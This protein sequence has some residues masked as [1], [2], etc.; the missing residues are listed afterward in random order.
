M[1]IRFWRP[2]RSHEAA[3]QSRAIRRHP[4]MGTTCALRRSGTNGKMQRMALVKCQEE[5]DHRCGATMTK[6]ARSKA[7][8]TGGSYMSKLSSY[9]YG[10]VAFGAISLAATGA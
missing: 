5:A 6:L 3:K 8:R 7:T 4:T 1:A 9:L 2:C 10:S